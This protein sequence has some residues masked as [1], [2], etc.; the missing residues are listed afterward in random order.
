MFDKTS[1]KQIIF[2]VRTFKV[3]FFLKNVVPGLGPNI[4]SILSGLR[5]LS[6][7]SDYHLRVVHISDTLSHVP[8]MNLV[9]SI[10]SAVPLLQVLTVSF[11]LKALME[12]SR[13]EENLG[14]SS[15]EEE[16]PGKS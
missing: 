5:A 16:I 1:Y 11:D 10:L 14:S 6:R 15:L 12:W 4:F 2:F 13:P 3:Y 9:H 7:H 8:C